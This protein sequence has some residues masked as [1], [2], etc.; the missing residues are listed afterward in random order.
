MNYFSQYGFRKIYSTELASVEL[1]D[2]IRLD[3]D[4]GSHYQCSLT[5]PMRFIPLTTQS[6]LEIFLIF[7]VFRESPFSGSQV[8]W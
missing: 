8:T 1:V 4:K 2:R 3:I 5:Y 6:Y 7:M